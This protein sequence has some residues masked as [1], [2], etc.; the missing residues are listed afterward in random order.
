[1]K[2]NACLSASTPTFIYSPNWMGEKSVLLIF[3]F[4]SVKLNV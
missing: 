4:S 1:M 2:T 3:F